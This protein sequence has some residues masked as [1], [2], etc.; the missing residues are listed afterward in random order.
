MEIRQQKGLPV[1]QEGEEAPGSP[2]SSLGAFS[3]GAEGGGV[4][5]WWGL[6][7]WVISHCSQAL[8]EGLAGLRNQQKVTGAVLTR[9]ELTGP[10][11]RGF[12]VE[13]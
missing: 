6:S 7:S 1:T 9:V 13:G 5:W 3:V 12:S 10:G 2:P 8:R 11:G 4:G